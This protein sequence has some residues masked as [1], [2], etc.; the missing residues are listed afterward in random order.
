MVYVLRGYPGIYPYG[1]SPN[2]T[3]F[4]RY[5]RFLMPS[6]VDCRTVCTVRCC[7]LGT[8]GSCFMIVLVD[9]SGVAESLEGVSYLLESERI[10]WE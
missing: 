3:M 10:T 2:G 9:G 6:P 7:L 1:N 8:S 5:Y 4:Y